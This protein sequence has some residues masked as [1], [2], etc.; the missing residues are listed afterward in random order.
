MM[1]HKQKLGYIVWGA[2]IITFFIFSCENNDSPDII[3]VTLT[4]PQ[5]PLLPKI[6]CEQYGT[7]YW[8]PLWLAVADSGKAC[9]PKT[10]YRA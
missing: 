8:G 4:L 3:V 6:D 7:E 2:V 9:H 5:T 10:N 1:N